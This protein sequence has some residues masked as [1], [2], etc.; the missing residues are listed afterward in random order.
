MPST[1]IIRAEQAPVAVLALDEICFPEDHRVNV[2]GALW[3][4]VWHGKEA[5]GYA[6]LRPCQL[7]CNE[8]VGFLNRVGV[9]AEHRGHG[10]QKRLIRVRESAARSY[11]M[12]ELV[13]YCMGWNCASVNSLISCDYKF[14]RPETRYGGADAV[15]LRKTL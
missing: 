2:D 13:T 10:L 14:Y 5:V 6:G 9:V 12:T 11:G 7:P 1:Y 4:I 3:W 15:Y 8:G